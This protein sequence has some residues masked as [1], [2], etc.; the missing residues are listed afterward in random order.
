[1][2]TKRPDIGTGRDLLALALF[3]LFYRSVSFFEKC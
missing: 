3:G 2:T 1:M